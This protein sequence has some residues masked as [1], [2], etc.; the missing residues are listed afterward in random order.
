LLG[1]LG[2]STIAAGVDLAREQRQL[3]ATFAADVFGYSRAAFEPIYY[4]SLMPRTC[5]CALLKETRD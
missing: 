2:S 1:P 5:L 3:A 4:S